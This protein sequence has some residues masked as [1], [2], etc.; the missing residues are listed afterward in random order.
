MSENFLQSKLF[1]GIVLGIAGLVILV[2]VFGLGVYVGM[3][4]ADFSFRWA[5]EYHQN[6]GGPQ[7]GIFGNFFGSE[8]EFANSNGSY[9]QII[10][11]D[12]NILTVKDNDG[13][14]TEKT[15][16][17]GDKTIIILQR[18]NIK[19]S[20]LKIGENIVVIGSPNN[21]GQI[22]AEL[23]RVMPAKPVNPS[24]TTPPPVNNPVPPP[25]QGS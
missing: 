12:G 10:K 1:K 9:G 16:L 15:I 7:G 24:T 4:K 21:D 13:D 8:K 2:F 5:E 18:K 25:T 11:I 20:D 6:F 19:L 17:V 3:E 22:Q 23:I 14:N